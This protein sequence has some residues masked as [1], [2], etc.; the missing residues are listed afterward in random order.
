VTRFTDKQHTAADFTLCGS[1]I[2]TN[3]VFYKYNT[4]YILE[5]E[6]Y[7]FARHKFTI[8][9]KLTVNKTPNIKTGMTLCLI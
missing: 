7:K 8:V 4:E 5:S 6:A 3:A 9:H 2:L 1:G